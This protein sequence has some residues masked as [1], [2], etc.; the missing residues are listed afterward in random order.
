MIFQETIKDITLASAA[1]MA[2]TVSN[3][4]ITNVKQKLSDLSTSQNITPSLV[5]Q[6]ITIKAINKDGDF[7]KKINADGTTS[8]TEVKEFS[9]TIT[10]DDTL[11]SVINKINA[12]SGV[13]VFFD[14]KTKQFSITAKNTGKSPLADDPL[15]TNIN[16]SVGAIQLTGNFFTEVMK[17]DGL[18]SNTV[19]ITNSDRGKCYVLLIMV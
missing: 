7:D 16:E 8:T 13:T 12:D 6:T 4:K 2:S 11:E 15:T 10:A 18:N 5:G 19:G 1:R 14:E 9:Y 3:N 17:M